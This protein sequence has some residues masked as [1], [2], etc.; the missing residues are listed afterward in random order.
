M[1]TTPDP[2][3]AQCS[4]ESLLLREYTLEP[5]LRDEAKL[6]GR[7]A[8]RTR[9][10]TEPLLNA[11]DMLMKKQAA[12]VPPTFNPG[13]DVPLSALRGLIERAGEHDTATVLTRAFTDFREGIL[14]SSRR[15]IS[16]C[17]T[18]LVFAMQG[19]H[20][21]AFASLRTASQV[22]DGWARHHHLYGLIHG[23]RGDREK[24]AF[25]LGMAQ[26]RE[27]FPAAR[28]RIEDALRAAKD[29]NYCFEFHT[30]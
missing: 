28:K 16:C 7:V 27:P 4:F 18:A 22:N 19:K 15:Y 24:A 30:A 23:V 21:N 20:E 8:E 1:N 2:A 25:E 29:P 12:T 9:R 5:G 10:V 14:S 13:F 26:A 11:L 6:P 3:Q 17:R